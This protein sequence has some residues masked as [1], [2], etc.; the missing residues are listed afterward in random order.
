MY[1]TK[2]HIYINKTKYMKIPQKQLFLLKNERKE[3][4]K[5]QKPTK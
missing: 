5:Q 1:K 3:K 4:R 2:T